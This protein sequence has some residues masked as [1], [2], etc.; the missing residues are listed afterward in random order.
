MSSSSLPGAPLKGREGKYNAGSPAA[1]MKKQ[2]PMDGGGL[3][4]IDRPERQ[5][6]AP[7]TWPPVNAMVKASFWFGLILAIRCCWHEHLY[8]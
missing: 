7:K 2:Q 1:C 8:L 3:V 5:R 6:K 4:V